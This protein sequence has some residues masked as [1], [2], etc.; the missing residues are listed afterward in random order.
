MNP[1]VPAPELLAPAGSF[2]CLKAA[3]QSGAD[4]VYL[5]LKTGSARMGAENFTFEELE[6][7]LRYAHIRG[8]RVYLALNTLFLKKRLKR[9]TKRQK[10]RRSSASTR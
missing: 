7:A 8:V 4:A 9:D 5:G 3:V 10:R 2:A 6:Q 1:D